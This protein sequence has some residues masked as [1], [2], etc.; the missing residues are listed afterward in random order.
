MMR[1]IRAEDFEL[2]QT[3]DHLLKR[4]IKEKTIK[5]LPLPILTSFAYMP[6]ITLLKFHHAGIIEMD[7]DNIF[8][9]LV[10]S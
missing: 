6:I 10:S 8:N 4:G 9:H 5:S 7:E 3:I 2:F 1:N